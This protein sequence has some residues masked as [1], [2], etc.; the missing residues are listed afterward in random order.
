M[1]VYILP[2][3]CNRR[4]MENGNASWQPYTAKTDMLFQH[5]IYVILMQR[6]QV[7]A[8]HT[9]KLKVQKLKP[10]TLHVHI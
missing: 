2:T 3:V 6:K 8:I 10:Y 7:T 1:N 4:E 5:R 9:V